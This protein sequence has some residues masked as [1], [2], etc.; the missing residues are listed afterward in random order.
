[1]SVLSIQLGGVET[2]HPQARYNRYLNI[3]VKCQWARTAK[4]FDNPNPNFLHKT[5]HAFNH[6]FTWEH[7][8][9]LTL[10]AIDMYST[11]TTEFIPSQIQKGVIKVNRR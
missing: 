11:K 6:A 5:V 10:A 2:P 1:M 7:S 8:C 3:Y 4:I 9:I